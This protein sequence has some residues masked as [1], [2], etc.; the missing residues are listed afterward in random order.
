MAGL[1]KLGRLTEFVSR[2]VVVGYV[3]GAAV[4]IIVSQLY[5]LLGVSSSDK[6]QSIYFKIDYLVRHIKEFHFSTFC[7]GIGSLFFLIMANKFF[8]KIPAPVLML[9]LSR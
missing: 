5:A 7:L 3:V 1:F 6:P 8:K 4:A 2:S 9:A